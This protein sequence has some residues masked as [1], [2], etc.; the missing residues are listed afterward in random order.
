M[1]TSEPPSQVED[2]TE[3]AEVTQAPIPDGPPEMPEEA[4]EDS[5]EGVDAFAEYYLDVWDYASMTGDVAPMRNLGTEACE[6]CTDMVSGVEEL[7]DEGLRADGP[8]KEVYMVATAY[9]DEGYL[10]LI[11]FWEG[12]YSYVD[13]AG[14][15]EWDLTSR[16]SIS[17]QMIVVDTPGVG[18]QVDF[19]TKVDF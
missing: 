2:Q 14:E 15:V 18:R 13:E 10:T 16:E 6:F 19:M 17:L 3:A 12:G 5:P 4:L 1:A 7:A 11:K 8:G 9:G